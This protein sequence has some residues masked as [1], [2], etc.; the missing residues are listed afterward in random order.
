MFVT[1]G[2]EGCWYRNK[3]ASGHTKAL[4]GIHVIDTTGAGDIFGGTAIA[5]ILKTGKEPGALDDYDL[6]QITSFASTAAGLST[7]RKGGI[8]SIPKVQTVRRVLRKMNKT[9]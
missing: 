9:K 7:T 4:D 6:K 2:P 8:S 1:C 5:Q 3:L